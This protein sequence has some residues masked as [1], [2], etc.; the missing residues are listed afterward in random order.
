MNDYIGSY[1][2]N[3]QGNPMAGSHTV[4]RTEVYRQRNVCQ[5]IQNTCDSCQVRPAS[6]ILCREV[7]GKHIRFIFWHALEKT[8]FREYNNWT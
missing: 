1:P 6:P 5:N 8:R 7:V 3:I 4:H 2:Q